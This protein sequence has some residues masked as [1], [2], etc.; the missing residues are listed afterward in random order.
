MNARKAKLLRKLSGLKQETLA[1][2]SGEPRMYMGDPK[3]KR[4][5]TVSDLA[6]NVVATFQTATYRLATNS[7]RATY[8]SLKRAN[9]SA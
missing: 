5:K 3:T 7:M 8:R 9:A 4:E 6:G 2:R 1:E